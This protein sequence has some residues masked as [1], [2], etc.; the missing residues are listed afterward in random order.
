MSAFGTG[1][2]VLAW[3]KEEAHGDNPPLT[4]QMLARER[5]ERELLA[6]FCTLLNFRWTMD[7]QVITIDGTL[8]AFGVNPRITAS[9]RT[10]RAAIG[11]LSNLV[12]ILRGSVSATA[13]DL[14]RYRACKKK[15]KVPDIASDTGSGWE[16]P[17][18]QET[19]T[20]IKRPRF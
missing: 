4:E 12:D 1:F 2:S 9:E 6:D 8:Y 5:F 17:G 18:H 16:R 15:W 10:I 14:A 11:E 19:S 7:V 13:E 3:V 20:P